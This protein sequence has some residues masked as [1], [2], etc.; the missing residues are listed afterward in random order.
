MYFRVVWSA[1]MKQGGVGGGVHGGRPLYFRV[2]RSAKMKR[3][4]AGGLRMS[5][6]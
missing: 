4:G 6:I 5:M 1:N 3:G 2:V